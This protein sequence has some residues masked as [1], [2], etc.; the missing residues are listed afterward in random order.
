MS[1]AD[2]Q[3]EATSHF[4][5]S[6][7]IKGKWSLTQ[8]AFDQLLNSFSIDREQAG[9]EYEIVRRKL[10]RFFEWRGVCSPD[11]CADET[12]NR[13]ARK[14][15]EGESIENLNGYF[16]GV[17]R[18]VL[19]EELKDRERLPVSME[20][21]ASRLKQTE[22]EVSTDP[23]LDCLDKCL[24]SLFPESRQLM[25]DYYREERRAKIEL[26]QQLADRLRIP[27][28]ALRIRVHRIRMSLEVC[29]TKCQKTS[30]KVK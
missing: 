21:A 9:A 24:E 4:P 13:V 25:L 20:D 1:S 22:E 10:A 28:N 14:I 2:S 15:Y 26:R 23:R 6:T 29:I 16:Y 30:Q 3:P 17:A 7:R 18:L 5:G 11:E 12:I 27:L 19:K 8:E